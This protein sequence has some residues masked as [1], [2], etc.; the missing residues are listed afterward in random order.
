MSNKLHSGTDLRCP[1]APSSSSSILKTPKTPRKLKMVP[2]PTVPDFS[3]LPTS[4]SKMN[5]NSQHNTDSESNASSTGDK[6]SSA[7][8]LYY[9]PRRPSALNLPPNCSTSPTPSR[10]DSCLEGSA[11]FTDEGELCKM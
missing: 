10:T 1:S 2:M 5:M 11:S 4:L 7:A 8:T 6:H 3:K 9:L